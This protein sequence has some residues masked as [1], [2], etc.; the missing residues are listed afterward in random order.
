MY[1][2]IAKREPQSLSLGVRRDLQ[3]HWHKLSN[4]PPASLRGCSQRA[5]HALGQQRLLFSFSQEGGGDIFL[6]VFIKIKSP[7]VHFSAPCF[8]HGEFSRSKATIFFFF[9]YLEYTGYSSKHLTCI[10]PIGQAL[11]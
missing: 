5:T 8:S 4:K 1:F 2:E 9:E 3:G 10:K 6:F 11:L 7:H